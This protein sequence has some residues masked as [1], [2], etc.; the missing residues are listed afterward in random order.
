MIPILASGAGG[1]AP[2]VLELGGTHAFAPSSNGTMFPA[3]HLDISAGDIIIIFITISNQYGSSY[4]PVAANNV[5]F[6][7][8]VEDFN[9]IVAHTQSAQDYIWTETAVK[10]TTATASGLG[11]FYYDAT[12]YSAMPV[13]YTFACVKNASSVVVNNYTSLLNG[14]PPAIGDFS[15]SYSGQLVLSHAA[16]GLNGNRSG[17]SLSPG[18]NY[19]DSFVTTSAYTMGLGTTAASCIATYSSDPTA[20]VVYPS[21]STTSNDSA[22]EIVLAIS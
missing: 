10:Y 21:Y 18:N 15:G 3:S 5:Q 16:V 4:I 19:H 20:D 6:V 2:K 14:A 9:S 11:A 1:A 12:V 7:D 22:N 17:L 8:E 13:V